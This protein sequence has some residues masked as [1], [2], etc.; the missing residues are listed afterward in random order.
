[1]AT[2]QL[3]DP[4]SSRS[5]LWS[6]CGAHVLQDGLVAVQYVLL[7]ILAQAFGLSYAQVGAL[8][9]VSSTA[10]TLLE[11]PSGILAERLGERRLMA[12]GL[13]GAGCGYLGVAWAPGFAFIVACFFLAG[14]GAAFQH[15]LSSALIVKHHAGADRRR[16]LGTFNASGDAGKLLFTGLFSMAVGVGLAWF[17]VVS[18]LALAAMVFGAVILLLPG[19]AFRASPSAMRAAAAG[20]VQNTGTTGNAERETTGQPLSPWRRWC[21]QW[22]ISAPSSFLR[23]AGMVSVDTLVQS[24]F[25]T[26]LA[27]VLL[28]KGAGAS[29]AA[30]GVTIALAG[31]MGGKYCCGLLAARLGDRRTF[32]LVQL[33][34]ATSLMLLLVL[35]LLPAL[36]LLP[37]AGVF[38]Q[39]SSTVTYGTVPDFLI[40][41]RQS[42]GYSLIYSVGSLA[43]VAG[44]FLAGFVADRAGLS[45]MVV[46]LAVLT[47]LT[48]VPSSVLSVQRHVA[49][50]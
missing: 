22:G 25:L 10:L 15:S 12:A 19:R 20:A 48:L 3:S 14:V 28:D 50:H 46:A 27:F 47:L 6:A 49:V 29:L 38:I 42:R 35:P 30:A 24:V 45:T 36:L 2:S 23:L 11:I 9:A 8:R 18:L 7:P 44:P 33:L 39:G 21:E 32:Q 40:A 41:E 5:A 13:V 26:F 16:A 37:V 34:S 17:Q 1:M 43:A 4:Q 31:G